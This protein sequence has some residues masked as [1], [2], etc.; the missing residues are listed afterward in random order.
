MLLLTFPALLLASSPSRRTL[1]DAG[2]HR[3]TIRGRDMAALIVAGA[4]AAGSR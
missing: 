2:G 4:S 3:I 1:P